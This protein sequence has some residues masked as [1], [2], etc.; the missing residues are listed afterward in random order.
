MI[1]LKETE[2]KYP[3]LES[4]FTIS[5]IVQK[6]APAQSN[7]VAPQQLSPPVYTQP[8]QM[9]QSKLKI[10]SYF[11]SFTIIIIQNYYLI[12]KCFYLDQPYDIQ[13]N[14]ST[15]KDNP[16]VVHVGGNHNSHGCWYYCVICCGILFCCPCTVCY[17][18]SKH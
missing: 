8:I 15:E 3:L 2:P 17:L 16:H 4:N 7:Q 14:H 9:S 12:M 5:K 11:F 6:F 18:I 10:L 1:Q 13:S